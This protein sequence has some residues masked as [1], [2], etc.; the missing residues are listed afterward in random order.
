MSPILQRL[1][2]WLFLCVWSSGYAVAKL[3][4]EYTDPLN[5][6][7][8]RY[9]GASLFVLPIIWYLR[10]ALP[11]WQ[12]IKGLIATGFFLH[13]GHFGTLYIGMKLG[14]SANIMSLF[15]AS[16]PVLIILAS[17][18]FIKQWP[19]WQVWLGLLLGLSGA[20]WVIGIDMQGQTGYLLGAL[21]GFLAVLGMSIGQV[22]E[23]QRKIHIHPLMA[24][25]VQYV[26]AALVS[27]PLAWFVE[28]FSFNPEPT[29][30]LSTAHLCIVNTVVG[31]MLMFAMVRNG[32][33]AQATSIMFLVPAVA[34]LLAWPIV[35]E[36]VPFIAVPGMLLAMAGAIWT[37]RVSR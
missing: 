28:G 32:S 16:Q 36:T 22:I 7:A 9:I 25:G 31:I 24:T 33:L 19:S 29:F 8:Y 6:L 21:L 3:A 2:P 12:Q 10:L 23:K 17:A 27:I 4:L 34:A 35:G 14:A 15:A 13:I 11:H 1:L 26:F 5:L 30:F 20:A 37:R 18:A